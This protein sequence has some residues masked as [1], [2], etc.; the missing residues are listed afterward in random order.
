MRE[1][2]RNRHTAGRE[3]WQ[4]WSLCRSALV[5]VNVVSFCVARPSFPPGKH[6]LPLAPSLCPLQQETVWPCILGLARLWLVQFFS[7][8]SDAEKEGRGRS[9]KAVEGLGR[10]PKNLKRK[11]DSSVSRT[12]GLST[13]AYSRTSLSLP[14]CPTHASHLAASDR[15][16][17]RHEV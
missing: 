6:S 11:F 10:L 5:G 9:W 13:P 1:P 2:Q 12:S 16:Y 17:C 15:M 7:S 4:G 14:T 3:R 8:W